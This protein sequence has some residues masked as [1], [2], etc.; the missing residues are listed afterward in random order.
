MRAPSLP[1]SLTPPASKI[2]ERLHIDF[3]ILSHESLG[4]NKYILV[5]CDEKTSYIAAA[6][7]KDKTLASLKAALDTII[8]TFNSRNH[9]VQYINSDD[10]RV[11]KAATLYLAS[12]GIS[13]TTTPAQFHEKRIERHIQTLKAKKRSI[14]ASLS[15]VL[16][17]QLDA[18]AYHS[19]IHWWNHMP[20]GNTI[21]TTPHQLVMGSKF[22]SP[23]FAFGDVGLFYSKKS[24]A[25]SV[26]GIFISYGFSNRYL[27][28]YVPGSGMYSKYHFK[29]QS[30]I[31]GAWKF[32]P[33]LASSKPIT[34]SGAFQ[35][36]R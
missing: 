10:E 20:N 14:E 19:E 25:A 28:A 4:G 5:S 16:P 12:R 3:I 24:D 18:E 17:A 31:P 30:Y 23:S 15:Y 6:G 32:I 7:M 1:S 33:R 26:W 21:G 22:T 27:R 8:G 36:H 35:L 13:I 11:M 9:R 2:G 34:T 29:P